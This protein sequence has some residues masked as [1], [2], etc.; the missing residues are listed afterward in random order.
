MDKSENYESLMDTAR[1]ETL[2]DGIFA[3]AM[4]LLVLTLAV[5]TLTGPLSNLIVQNALLDLW[6]NFLA[7]TLSFFLLAVYWNVHHRYYKQIKFIN[8]SLLWINIIWLFF[9]V[10]VPFSASLVGEYGS[11]PI[12]HVFFNINLLGIASFLYLNW[13]F[14]DRND[15]IHEKV[16]TAQITATKKVNGIFIGLT[17]VALILSY[18][19]PSYCEMVYILIIPLE[20]IVKRIG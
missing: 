15:F 8:R 3:I 5:P 11:Y 20:W 4:T 10:L 1:I 13:H 12:S 14:A 17:L 16:E 7:V 19:I 9:I 6:P 18:I 2:V